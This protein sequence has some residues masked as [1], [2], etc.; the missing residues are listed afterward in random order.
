MMLIRNFMRIPYH[1]HFDCGY[2]CLLFLMNDQQRCY[3]WWKAL[4]CYWWQQVAQYIMLSKVCPF[5]PHSPT[6]RSKFPSFSCEFMVNYIWVL[7]VAYIL[8]TNVFLY[9]T[10][11]GSTLILNEWKHSNFYISPNWEKLRKRG[12]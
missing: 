6:G 2:L 9:S 12:K 8:S 10:S 5:W 1:Y 7:W 4:R 3:V 11:T